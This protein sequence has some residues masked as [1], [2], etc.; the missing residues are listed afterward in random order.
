MMQMNRR[1]QS[2]SAETLFVLYFHIK[3]KAM[4]TIL[5]FSIFSLKELHHFPVKNDCTSSWSE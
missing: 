5:T 3:A 1:S 4:Y 2:M